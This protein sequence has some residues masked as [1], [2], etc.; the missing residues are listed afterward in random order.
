MMQER[1]Q[2]GAPSALFSPVEHNAGK[3]DVAVPLAL[4]RMN[5]AISRETGTHDHEIAVAVAR[6]LQ[7]QVFD[8][9]LV[10]RIAHRMHV[11]LSLVEHHD[12]RRT[13][14][15]Q[16]SVLMMS[17]APAVRES[18]YVRNLV[19]TTLE[20]GNEGHCVFIGRGAA[21]ILPP[22][23][24]LRVALMAPL[25]NRIHVVMQQLGL[26]APEAAQAVEES[27]RQRA[28]FSMA[29]FCRGDIDPHAFDLMLNTARLTVEQC[30]ELIVTAV[31]DRAQPAASR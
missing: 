10:E 26:S 19:E 27:D 16:E 5:I 13:H 22:E 11:P 23:N 8:H 3:A 28:H 15:L 2:D 20:L 12:E 21:W 17:G 24:T 29:H 18:Q 25:G 30:A 14:W 9:E 7:W 31:R 6:R 1:F 4:D